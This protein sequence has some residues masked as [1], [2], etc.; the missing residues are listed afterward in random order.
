MRGNRQVDTLV[1]HHAVSR[2]ILA[3][4]NILSGQNPKYFQ[5]IIKNC[6]H[7]RADDDF[8]SEALRGIRH[9][10]FGAGSSVNVS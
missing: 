9:Y 10:D 2:F 7:N 1:A 3:Q 4:R 6:H 8:F 5:D